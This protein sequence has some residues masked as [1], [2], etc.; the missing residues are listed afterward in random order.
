[1]VG[2]VVEM[3]TEIVPV[4]FPEL[5]KL[6]WN[7]PLRP[8]PAEEAFALYDRNWRFVDHDHLTKREA[9]LI[10]ILGRQFGNGFGLM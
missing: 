3:Q 8:L 2:V 1:M 4:A 7:R 10:R 9:D 5:Q 6:V